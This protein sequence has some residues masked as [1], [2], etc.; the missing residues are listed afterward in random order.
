MDGGEGEREGMEET[1]CGG[2][3]EGE[4]R[5]IHKYAR[6]VHGGFQIPLNSIARVS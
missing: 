2:G 6:S 4:M 1:L 3:Q 5:I